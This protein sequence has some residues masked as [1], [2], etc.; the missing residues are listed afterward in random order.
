MR[1]GETKRFRSAPIEIKTSYSSL[2]RSLDLLGRKQGN[3]VLPSRT[4]DAAACTLLEFL[5]QTHDLA[6]DTNATDASRASQLSLGTLAD[7]VGESNPSKNDHNGGTVNK[8]AHVTTNEKSREKDPYGQ[9]NDCF[10]DL[11]AYTATQV[12]SLIQQG[13]TYLPSE[14]PRD[15]WLA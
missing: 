8:L 2:M 7:D 14:Y 6:C 13:S 1:I 12:E 15:E 10:W 3:D 4:I 11:V 5:M 9:N